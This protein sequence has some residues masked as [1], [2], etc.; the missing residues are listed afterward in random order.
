M[1]GISLK[2]RLN[3]SFEEAVAGLT[4]VPPTEKSGEQ[5][6]SVGLNSS[7]PTVKSVDP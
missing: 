3:A 2:L 6:S 7:P 5:N 4:G 1:S